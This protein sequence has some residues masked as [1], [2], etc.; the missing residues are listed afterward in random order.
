MTAR[1]NCQCVGAFCTCNGHSILKDGA[2]YRL[3]V[4]MMDG[5]I[6]GEKHST[7]DAML[8]DSDRAYAAMK[9]QDMAAWRGGAVPTITAD[10]IAGKDPEYA[11]GIYDGAYDA[12]RERD[13]NAWRGR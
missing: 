10:R 3:P 8:T 6:S 11:R 9:A 1:D 7:A 13:R 4:M 2:R 12:M 5:A